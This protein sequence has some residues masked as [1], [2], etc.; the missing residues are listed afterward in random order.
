M[1]D[2][3]SDWL[4]SWWEVNKWDSTIVPK[5]SMAEDKAY[6]RIAKGY[7]IVFIDQEPSHKCEVLVKRAD[8]STAWA[9]VR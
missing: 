2:N 9:K 5:R 8:G 7:C 1:T 3:E 6:E 4:V